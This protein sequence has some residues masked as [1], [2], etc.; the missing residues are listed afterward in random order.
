MLKRMGLG[1]LLITANGI[2]IFQDIDVEL[3]KHRHI[4]FSLW[5]ANILSKILP[6]NVYLKLQ[7]SVLW[8]L[9]SFAEKYNVKIRPFGY[10]LG[11]LVITFEEPDT[12]FLVKGS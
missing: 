10:R 5:T 7:C 4:D 11:H 6:C 2:F 1:M 3:T 9:L 8:H 12:M